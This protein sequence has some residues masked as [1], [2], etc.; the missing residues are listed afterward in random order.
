MK[1]SLLII[2]I[3]LSQTP[4]FAQ[5]KLK[6]DISKETGDTVFYTSDEKLYVSAGDTYGTGRDKKTTI[7]D[8]LKSSVLKYPNGFVLE[9]SVQTGRTNSFSVYTGQS[10]KL[11]MNDGSVITL[12]SRSGYN[13]KKSSLGYGS[14]LFAFYSL[15]A[16][17]IE[18]LKN[19]MI[20][21]IRLE[22]SM[23][24]FDYPL[25]EKAGN[26]IAGQLKSF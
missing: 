25:K 11:M 8:Y 22:S 5:R 1:R 9:F 24:S 12:Y 16:N 21:S 7:G 6:F 15:P 17:A 3:L 20:S 19:G 4:V 13:S 14:W 26:I 18:T 10:A 2:I 23:G